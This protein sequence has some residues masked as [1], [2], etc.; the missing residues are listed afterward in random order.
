MMQERNESLREEQTDT[1]TIPSNWVERLKVKWEL[2]SIWQVFL[3]ILVFSVTGSTVVF[4]RKNLFYLLGF[5]A[6]TPFWLKTVTYL[7]FVM[8]A[9]QILLLFYGSLVGQFRF[10]W[11]KEKKI[12]RKIIA[13]FKR[14]K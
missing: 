14:K 11:N 3:V 13:L 6:T 12:A 1:A 5:D 7:V 2:D 8:P 9:Y 4:L 10:F